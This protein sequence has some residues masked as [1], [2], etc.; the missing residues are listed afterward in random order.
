[1]RE[2]YSGGLKAFGD[3]TDFRAA[4]LAGANYI[5]TMQADI[6]EDNAGNGDPD[7]DPEDAGWDWVL[8]DFEHSANAS[9]KNLYGVCANAAYQAYLID[10]D[11]A[12]FTVMRDAA[13]YIVTAGPANIRSAADMVFL[14]NFASLTGDIGIFP[15][16][17]RNAAAAI[18]AYRVANFG[19]TATAFAEY[20]RDAR[21]NGG[22]PNGI[23]PWDLA[24]YV[25]SLMRLD[26]LYPGNGFDVDAAAVAEVIYEDSF[27]ANPG[28]FQPL[29]PTTKGFDPTY[30]DNKFWFYPGGVAGIIA[31]FEATGL[32]TEEIPA[33]EA[34]LLEC[35]YEDGAFS[36]Q[37]GADTSFDDRDWQTSA[38]VIYALWDHLAHTP[39]NLNA[40]YA[41]AAWL[42]ATQD[43]SGA[44]VYD[45]GNHYPEI[46]AEAAAAVAYGYFAAGAAVNTTVSGPDP[47][48]CGQ[49]KVA[50]FGYDRGEGT[51]G[52]RGY[53]ITFEVTGPVSF[54]LGNIADAGGL[55]GVGSNYFFPVDNGDGTY[56]VND[57][58]LGATAGL[59]ADADLFTVTMTTTGDGPVDVNIL[60][61]RMRDPDNAFI[62]ADMNGAGFTVDCTAPG[63]VAAIT[64][65]PGHDKVLV[66]W[67]HDGTDTAIYEVYRG[68]WYDGTPGV[69]AY[70][71]YD[72]LAGNVIPSRPA[73]RDAA[74]ASA[75]WE[76]AGTVAVGTTAFVDAWLD[77]TDRGV[78]YYEVF[79]V[80]GVGNAGIAAADG[81]DRATNYWLGDVPA[82]IDGFVD[83]DD[84]TVLGAA[85]A[86]QAGDVG[87]NNLV[88]VGPTDDWSRVGIP[89]TDSLIDFEDLMIFSMN[90]NVV[91]PAKSAGP[92]S[93]VIELAWVKRDDGRWALQLVS[94]EGLKGVR[95]R[96]NAPASGVQPGA[97]LAGQAEKFFLVD[98]GTRMDVNLALMGR[99]A[100]IGGTG[101]LFVIELAADIDVRDLAVDVRGADNSKLEYTFEKAAGDTPTAFRLGANF[102]NPFNPMTKIVFALP[103]AQQVELS[104]YSLDGRKVATLLNE[105]RGPGSHEVVW[106]GRNDAGLLVA[107]GTYFYRIDAGPYSQVRKMPLM[108]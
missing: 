99:N 25:T 22:W 11:P 12:M 98:P 50:T 48:Q 54:G 36:Y 23:I 86:T 45:G 83:V 76:L 29:E 78:Y 88:D 100:A 2:F 19:G 41:G 46:G 106:T 30:A 9:P 63:P 4:A 81:N 84:L 33:L 75:E 60:S 93:A 38:Y 87:Y 49:T 62:F 74:A 37:Y 80:D 107:S 5:R 91:G 8:P 15:P 85:F 56:T 71:E 90:Y 42:A 32:H 14:L 43:P 18:W 96:A 47:V 20:I 104:V 95:V 55:A 68:L 59:L 77:E 97:L 13:D 39:A 101:E 57:V 10:P 70:P 58:I 82:Y 89:V 52:L 66:E 24:P 64:A 35:Q 65:D 34:I 51:P 108:K 44:W 21:G 7:Q 31:A 6:T 26:A 92:I 72:D 73:D 27:N 105:P 53:E 69:S 79:A 3:P 67:T 28:F 94:G 1:M 16:V 61:Y 102:P 17:Y 40:V 103:E